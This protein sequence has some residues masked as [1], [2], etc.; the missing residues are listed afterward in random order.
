[1]GVGWGGRAAA[2]GLKALA[3]PRRWR[4]SGLLSGE[5]LCV[6]HLAEEMVIAQPLVSHH[7]KVLRAAGLVEAEKH[8]Q[9]TY[10][11]LRRGALEELSAQIG[12][13]TACCLTP[14]ERLMPCE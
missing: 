5:E 1:M 14:G 9:W 3:G 11:R 4:I 10:Y 8:R 6:G 12:A 7:L 13:I 2:G